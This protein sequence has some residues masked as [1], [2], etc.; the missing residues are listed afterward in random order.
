[1]RAN[2]H[3]DLAMDLAAQA[4]DRKLARCWAG[5][6][7]RR[8][9]QLRLLGRAERYHRFL[10]MGGRADHE[11]GGEN[12]AMAGKDAIC[13]HATEDGPCDVKVK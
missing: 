11:D 6:F 1:M 8:V 7:R 9:E 2:E 10:G 12:E 13:C 3:A 5:P 4:V